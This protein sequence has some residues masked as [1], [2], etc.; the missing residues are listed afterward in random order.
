LPSGKSI[1]AAV[2][3]F[4]PAFAEWPEITPKVSTEYKMKKLK[5]DELGRPN[6]ETFREMKKKPL[7]VILDNIRSMNNVGSVFRTCDAFA[8][9]KLYLCGITSR[10]P[11]REIHKTAL[12]ATESVNW[13]YRENIASLLQELKEEGYTILAAEQTSDSIPLSAFDNKKA[14]PLA[15]ILGNEVE[16][17]SEEALSFAD[18]II[19]IPQSGT[20]HSLNIAVAAGIMIFFLAEMIE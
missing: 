7:I 20:K 17:V 12:G 5:L 14:N 18:E 11:H 4:F 1:F 9:D 16:G 13:E 3:D 2:Q 8:I 19:E 6:V 10:P 15:L